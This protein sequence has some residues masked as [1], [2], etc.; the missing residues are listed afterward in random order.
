MDEDFLQWLYKEAAEGKGGWDQQVVFKVLRKEEVDGE[1]IV[2]SRIKPGSF[3]WRPKFM[4]IISELELKS[5]GPAGHHQGHTFGKYELVVGREK[6]NCPVY[7]QAHSKEIPRTSSYQLYM[8]R[9][10]WSPLSPFPQVER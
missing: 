6:D 9:C 7:K 4:R 8:Y 10:E 2:S 5:S 1:T 3:F